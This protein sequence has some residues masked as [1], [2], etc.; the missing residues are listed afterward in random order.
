MRL[1]VKVVIDKL[2]NLRRKVKFEVKLVRGGRGEYK[3][4]VVGWLFC[5]VV[6]VGIVVVKIGN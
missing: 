6:M 3:G 1:D 2:W 5:R 4:I